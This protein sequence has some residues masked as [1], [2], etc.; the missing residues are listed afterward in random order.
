MKIIA[1]DNF[2]REYIAD[3]LIAENVPSYYAPSIAEFLQSRHG[4]EQASR[5]YKAVDDDTVLC[6]G[7][8]D[9]V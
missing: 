4:G 8:E 2:A 5:Y 3:V 9:L 6:R 1:V 7:M